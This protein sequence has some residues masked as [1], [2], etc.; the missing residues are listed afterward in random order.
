MQEKKPKY[1]WKRPKE[2]QEMYFGFDWDNKKIW[3]LDLLVV[4]IN[5]ENLIWHFDLPFWE[6]E[7]T[8]EYNCSPQDVLDAKEGTKLHQERIKNADTSHPIDIYF[9]KEKSKYGILDGL[10]RVV[11]LYKSGQK[12][13]KVRILPEERIQDVLRDKNAV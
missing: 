8:Y 5:I 12:I 6:L 4:D 9:I 2:I 7:N 13:I 10:H 1:L 3:A 11:R